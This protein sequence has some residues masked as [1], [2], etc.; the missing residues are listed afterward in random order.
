MSGGGKSGVGL[1]ATSHLRPQEGAVGPPLPPGVP[2]TE[3]DPLPDWL[4]SGSAPSQ[5]A[6]PRR[7][8][9]DEGH[10]AR[11]CAPPRPAIRLRPSPAPPPPARHL[12]PAS[13]LP[14][15]ADRAG[16]HGGSERAAGP[17]PHGRL[18]RRPGGH[19]VRRGRRAALPDRA[20]VSA[21]GP[22][23]LGPSSPASCRPP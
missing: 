5:G 4:R 12:P 13:R 9:S 22:C 23:G 17:L 21:R 14:P 20:E 18:G 2:P 6:G 15:T 10:G 1:R 19:G 7:L 11:R 16:S 8:Q 3:L